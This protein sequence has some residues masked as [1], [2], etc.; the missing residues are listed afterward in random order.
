VRAFSAIRQQSFLHLL[1]YCARCVCP[2]ANL[3]IVTAFP[4]AALPAFIGTM[5]SSEPLFYVCLPYLLSL[6]RHT[7]FLV[8]QNRAS[9]RAPASLYLL[10]PCSR[11]GLPSILNLQHAMLSDPGRLV[12]LT[13]LSL[14]TLLASELAIPSPY[15][16]LSIS[17]LNHFS[18][19]LRP[20]GSLHLCLIFGITPADPRFTS[21]PVANLYRGGTLARQTKR[22]CPAALQVA[23]EY[24][25]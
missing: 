5:Q 20:V 15:P 12:Q 8:R 19:R 9:V 3:T 16:I 4:P 6:V 14:H 24:Y 2:L 17:R 10:H 18:L 11:P 13:I 21:R 7:H 25:S 23:P 22:P 1:R